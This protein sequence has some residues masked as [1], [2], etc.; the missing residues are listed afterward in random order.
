MCKNNNE[1]IIDHP[2][3]VSFNSQR[4]SSIRNLG[5]R[6]AE[7][8]VKNHIR[9]WNWENDGGN[10]WGEFE[11]VHPNMNPEVIIMGAKFLNELQIIGS[12]KGER[13]N[14]LVIAPPLTA[15]I[16]NIITLLIWDEFS[17]EYCLERL[18]VGSNKT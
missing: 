8:G 16:D 2:W 13:N 1:G 12:S 11:S 9:Q 7:M 14:Q 17:L 6:C 5:V 4:G 15:M 18:E 10:I 3:S